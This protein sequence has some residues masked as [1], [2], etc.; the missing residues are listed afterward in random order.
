MRGPVRNTAISILRLKGTTDIA[1]T[2]RHHSRKPERAITCTLT[3]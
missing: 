1:A 3:C 2:T